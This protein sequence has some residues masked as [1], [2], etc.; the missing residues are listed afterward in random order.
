MMIPLNFPPANLVISTTDQSVMVFDRIRRRHV[1]LTPEEWVRQHLIHY[2]VEHRGY[3]PSL[4]SVEAKL[5]LNRMT[6]RADVVC[7][8]DPNSKPW[9]VAECKAPEVDLSQMV[10][11][12]ALRYNMVLNAKY[13]LITNG[14][15]H[16]C[17]EMPGSGTTAKMI[18]V[19]PD[20]P[21]F[22]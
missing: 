11:D 7:W 18:G 13:V 8:V 19:I 17:Y 15:I 9:L 22:I 2:L 20:A 3:R 21:S 1:A 6:R 5:K 10:L 16:V 12:Q 4:I 14:L